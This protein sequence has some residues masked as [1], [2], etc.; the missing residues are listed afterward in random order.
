MIKNQAF[1]DTYY[2]YYI[3]IIISFIITYY[4]TLPNTERGGSSS[5]GAWVL[6]RLETPKLEF[7][8]LAPMYHNVI[9]G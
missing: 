2:N 5:F 1:T 6:F 7:C 4:T 8:K 9:L 3:T